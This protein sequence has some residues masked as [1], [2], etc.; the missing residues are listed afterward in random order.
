MF[1]M[2]EPGQAAAEK[3]AA[4]LPPGKACIASLPFKDANE[5]LLKSGPAALV[6]AF[7]DAAPWKPDGIISGSEFT[8]ETMMESPAVGYTL[9]YP[10]LNAKLRS[11]R[12]AEIHMLTAGS[13]IGKSTFAREVS[14]HLHQE[15]GLAIGNVFLEENNIKTVKGYVAIDNN[16]ALG[17][18]VET[19]AILTP[20]Q[21]NASLAKVIHQRMW[22][23]NHFGS[24]DSM[25]LLGK[26]R[27]FAAVCKVDFI[28]LDHISLVTSGTESSKE[29]ERKDIDILMTRLRSLVEETGVGV[30]CIVHLKRVQGKSFNEGGM[31][32]LS[33]L[34]GSGSLEQLS[35]NV[36]ALE[37]DQQA[38][39]EARF[40]S[41]IR[42]LKTRLGY[43]TGEADIVKYDRDTGRLLLFDDCPFEVA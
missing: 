19:P 32:S 29:G 37:R 2:D 33:D 41:Q 31:V 40:R 17:A 5:T 9:Q 42:V 26:L 23:Y 15:H 43:D 39:D 35:D 10:G 13:G 8:L 22:F 27:Y 38:E 7:W 21:W 34:R 6:R 14:Y 3:V 20:E 25:N 30:I 16:V 1:D 28:V 24:L 12:K 36:I 11:L 18:L 4:L